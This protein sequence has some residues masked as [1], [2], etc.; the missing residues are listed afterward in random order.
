[1]A[2]LTG[3]CADTPTEI[4]ISSSVP[5]IAVVGQDKLPGTVG[6]Y[7]PANSTNF[8]CVKNGY[9]LPVGDAFKEASR[10][11]FAQFFGDAHLIVDEDQQK[12]NIA[13]FDYVCQISIREVEFKWPLKRVVF[14]LVIAAK[15]SQSNGSVLF[16]KGVRSEASETAWGPWEDDYTKPLGSAASRAIVE[17]LKYLVKEIF[18]DQNVMAY[19]QQVRAREWASAFVG[20]LASD[21]LEGMANVL[22]GVARNA[23]ANAGHPSAGP[24][25]IDQAVKQSGVSLGKLTEDPSALASVARSLKCGL[26]MF[27]KIEPEGEHVRLTAFLFDRKSQ[28]VVNSVTRKERMDDLAALQEAVRTMVAELNRSRTLPQR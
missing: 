1:M 16:T 6:I 20:W 26:L 12:A 13:C 21:T 23:T 9:R 18:Q 8:V 15:L 17:A 2:L 3:G 28:S 10:D 27:G 5:Q 24:N 22:T 25:D 7:L 4:R 11:V 14:H 19:A